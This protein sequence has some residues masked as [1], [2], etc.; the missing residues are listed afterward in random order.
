MVIKCDIPNTDDPLLQIEICLKIIRKLENEISDFGETTL[1]MSFLNWLCPFSSLILSHKINEI[2]NLNKGKVFTRLPSNPDVLS[3]LQRI[4]FPLGKKG[5]GNTFL[6]LIHFSESPEERCKN[7]FK[8]IETTFPDSLKGDCI[9]Y[10]LSE[11]VDNIDQHSEYTHS[12]VMAQFFPKKN[13]V[14]IGVIDNG[15]SIPSLFEKNNI[16]FNKDTDALSDA[17]KGVSTKPEGYRGFGLSS[18]NKITTEGLG[19]KYYIISRKGFLISEKGERKV[20]IL[21]SPYKGTIVYL[22]FS[23]PKQELNIYTYIEK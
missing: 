8:F 1:D 4:G 15:I 11:L 10:L 22:R 16:F 12:S 13:I 9:N 21:P 17:L 2:S 7:L 18:T 23:A 6:P 20:Y 3:Y 19:G 5:I 14:D